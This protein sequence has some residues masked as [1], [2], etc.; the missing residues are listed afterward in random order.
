M[1]CF[2]MVDAVC[3]GERYYW[4]LMVSIGVC[5]LLITNVVCVLYEGGCCVFE[6]V[7]IIG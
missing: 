6:Y 3:V 7:T 4:C 2:M 1:L 5:W